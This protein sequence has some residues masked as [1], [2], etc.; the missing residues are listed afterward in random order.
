MKKNLFDAH[1]ISGTHWDR[2]WYRPFQEYRFLLVKLMDDLLD[3]METNPDFK[4]F[5]LDG[6]TSVLDDYMEIRPEQRERLKAL[7]GSGR[8]LIGPW[9]TMPDLFCPGDEALL[10]NLLLGRRVSREWGVEP[11]PVGFICDMFGHPSQMP[12]IFAGFGLSDVV[13]GR[14]VNEHTTPSYF[15]WE[16]PDGSKAFVFK[17]QDFMG[18]GAFA[19]P[20]TC[21]EKPTALLTDLKEFAAELEAAGTDASKR[22]SVQEKWFKVELARYVEHETERANGQT[23]CLMDS[24]DHMPPATDVANYLRRIQEACPEVTTTHSSLPLFFAKARKTAKRVP[25]RRGE[26]IEPSRDRSS[27]L[28][29]IPNCVSARVRLKQANDTCQ[30]LLGSWV[31]PLMALANIQGAG[32]P[33]RFLRHAWEQVLAITPTIRFV[34]VRLTRFIATCFSVSIRPVCWPNSFVPRPWPF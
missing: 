16:A 2:E 10:R 19:R 30:T 25:V 1:Y 28:W 34:A 26:L 29:L 11:M 6:Q 18:Y 24:M 21:L 13:L 9:F 12:Q 5:H 8:I 17:L 14:G 15:S 33:E 3:L 7:I 23:L 22:L 32:I 4:F 20:R 31:E 27:Y